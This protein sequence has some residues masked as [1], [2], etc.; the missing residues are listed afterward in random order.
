MHAG[1][2]LHDPLAVAVVLD[3][4]GA[5]EMEFEGLGLGFGVGEEAKKE[6]K[7]EE[8]YTVEVDVSNGE[9]VGRTMI[10][11]RDENEGGMRI[12]GNVDVGRFWDVVEEC[13]AR[14][15]EGLRAMADPP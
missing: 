13:I 1:P 3:D 7:E 6:M 8:R 2:P 14:A 11:R 10:R 4:I 15:E 12:M 9:H 5:E